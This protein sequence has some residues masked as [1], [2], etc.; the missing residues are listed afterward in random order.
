MKNI[1][2]AIYIS[3]NSKSS[4]IENANE[5][6]HTVSA[7]DTVSFLSFK[8]AATSFTIARTSL[9]GNDGDDII[10]SLCRAGTKALE[11][12]LIYEAKRNGWSPLIYP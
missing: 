10:E 5:N 12:R 6:L 2:T 11:R 7:T 9:G 8:S 1:L 3:N 4:I